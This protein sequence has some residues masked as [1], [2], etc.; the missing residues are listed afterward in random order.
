M[1]S[2]QETGASD[3]ADYSWSPFGPYAYWAKRIGGDIAK[4]IERHLSGDAPT[5]PVHANY[6]DGL[7]TAHRIAVNIA[8][9]RNGEPQ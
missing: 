3:A 2:P 1:I 9:I 8:A 4:E 7:I 5:P 6:F